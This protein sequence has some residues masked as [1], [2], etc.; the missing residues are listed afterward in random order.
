MASFK[1]TR[2][3]ALES[4]VD[5]TID[6]DDFILLYDINWS[7]NPESPYENCCYCET[8]H[9]TVAILNSNVCTLL[10]RNI[11]LSF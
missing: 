5:G 4:Y 11:L 10:L 2:N 3:L 6:E 7:K 9:L 8:E 1:E